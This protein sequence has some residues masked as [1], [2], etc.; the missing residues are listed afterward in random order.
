[1]NAEVEKSPARIARFGSVRCPG[2][3]MSALLRKGHDERFFGC[4]VGLAGLEVALN[5]LVRRR[6]CRVTARLWCT[7]ESPARASTNVPFAVDASRRACGR[8]LHV[9]IVG[10]DRCEVSCFS[11]PRSLNRSVFAWWSRVPARSVDNKQWSSSRRAVAWGQR[12]AMFGRVMRSSA[13][14]RDAVT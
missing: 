3:R 5:R 12:A 1:M 14:V 9:D 13:G 4:V 11:D 7:R 6:G 2:T 8:P 10:V